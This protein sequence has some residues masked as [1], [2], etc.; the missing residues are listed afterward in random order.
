MLSG[1][2]FYIDTNLV[3][4]MPKGKLDHSELDKTYFMKKMFNESKLAE[5]KGE[6]RLAKERLRNYESNIDKELPNLARLKG[7]KQLA[8]EMIE[9]PKGKTRRFESG[10]RTK[11][12]TEELYEKLKEFQ[13]ENPN[14]DVT[15]LF[16]NEKADK[17]ARFNH[18]RAF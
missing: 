16:E 11:R 8:Q 17:I 13:R 6:L 12:E 14:V 4:M 2:E 1:Q 9:D 18:K 7:F 15:Q 10:R 3:S 5:E